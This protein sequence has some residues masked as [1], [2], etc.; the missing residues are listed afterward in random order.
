ML[1]AIQDLQVINTVSGARMQSA[2]GDTV[3]ILIA[4]ND[5][6]N[7]M[8]HVSKT[9]T[10]LY[11]LDKGKSAP[12]KQGTQESQSQKMMASTPRLV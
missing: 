5:S 6:I 4:Q 11:A 12:E 3:F 7:K 8:T 10:S 2:S 9:I 1:S